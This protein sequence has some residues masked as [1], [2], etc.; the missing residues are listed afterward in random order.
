[1]S[2]TGCRYC[3][4]V[5]DETGRPIVCGKPI[6]GY[7]IDWGRADEIAVC[8]SH[9]RD[10]MSDDASVNALDGGSLTTNDDGELVPVGARS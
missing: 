6:V 3:I 7:A 8:E 9:A 4:E 1:M 2:N 5:D 10:A